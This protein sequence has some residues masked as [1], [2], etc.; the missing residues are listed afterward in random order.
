MN[1]SHFAYV[2][3]LVELTILLLKVLSEDQYGT[4]SPNKGH[5][6][7]ELRDKPPPIS[8]PQQPSPG[9]EPWRDGK[10]KFSYPLL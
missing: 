4:K 6:P 9:S 7:D 10:S 8:D 5:R 3:R 2:I 1:T